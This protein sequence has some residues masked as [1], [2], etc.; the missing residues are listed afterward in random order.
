MKQCFG[1]KVTVNDKSITLDQEQYVDDLLLRFNMTDCK[2][3]STPMKNNLKLN[4]SD[5]NNDNFP[6]Q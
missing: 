4:K 5:R 2:L 6:Y 1:M 3:V